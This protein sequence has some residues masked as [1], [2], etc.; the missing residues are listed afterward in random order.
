[1][2]GRRSGK[3]LSAHLL[4]LGVVAIWGATFPLVKG[5]LRDASPL[6]FNVVRMGLATLALVCV[7]FRQLRDLSRAAV[8]A[9]LAVGLFLGAGYQ[10]QTVGLSLTSATKSAF[11]TGLVVVFVPLFSLVPGVSAGRRP[12]FRWATLSGALLAFGGLALLTTPSGTTLADLFSHMTVGDLLTLLCAVAFAGHLLTLARVSRAVAA[13]PLA[14]L[15]VGFATLLMLV[16]LPVAG[17]I[18]AHITTRLVVAWV[19]TALLAT[20][21]A[22]TIQSW[23]QQHMPATHTAVFLSLEPVFALLTSRLFFGEQLSQRTFLGAALIL[24]GIAIIEFLTPPQAPSV[25]LVRS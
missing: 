8:M 4:L 25:D 1:M 24:S 13:G 18:S 3:S 6:L 15:Q 22:F 2:A 5:A 20:A 12:P 16:T 19:V 7:H 23:A 21:A 10:F 11:I 9:G 14:T 17:P